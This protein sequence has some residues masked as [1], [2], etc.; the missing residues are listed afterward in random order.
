MAKKWS[1]QG[2]IGILLGKYD[3]D[4]GKGIEE[5]GS[6]GAGK[7]GDDSHGLDGMRVRFWKGYCYRSQNIRSL[8]W[9][10]TPTYSFFS[11]LMSRV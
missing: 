7:I 4:R 3:E 2:W 5:Q 9:T 6:R 10:R 11:I 8:W 1:E